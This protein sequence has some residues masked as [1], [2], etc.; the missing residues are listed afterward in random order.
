LEILGENQIKQLDVAMVA[1]EK[2]TC[3]RP[4]YNGVSM[5][6]GRYISP[7][8]NDHHTYHL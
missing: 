8:N 4:R 7:I 1:T 3:P 6:S 5:L 2:L